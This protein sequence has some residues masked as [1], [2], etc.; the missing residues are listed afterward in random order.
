[1]TLFP[2]LYNLLSFSSEVSASHVQPPTLS[3]VSLL[4]F[5]NTHS[6]PGQELAQFPELSHSYTYLMGWH[7][8][9]S[10]PSHLDDLIDFLNSH[11]SLKN[12]LK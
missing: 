5:L 11:S 7:L 12:Q 9:P 8:K 3:K 1:M 2:S 10:P 4:I 6:S